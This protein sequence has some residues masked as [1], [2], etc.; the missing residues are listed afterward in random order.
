[1]KT[2][3]VEKKILAI[4]GCVEIENNPIDFDLAY[5]LGRLKTI[6]K[7]INQEL[8]IQRERVK[9]ELGIDEGTPPNEITKEKFKILEEKMRAIL[10]MEE[11]VEFQIKASLFRGS[12]VAP[13]S[14]EKLLD[15]IEDDLYS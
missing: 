15:Y 1:M 8:N 11:E 2:T 5:K 7:P 9:S 6:L 3:T 4:M 13:S 10:D 14:I 12:K